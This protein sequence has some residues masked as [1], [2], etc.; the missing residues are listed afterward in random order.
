M[1][2]IMGIGTAY[3]MLANLVFI[4]SNYLLHVYLGRHL[5]PEG[6]GVFGI[7]M[8]IYLINRSFLNTGFPKSVSKAI[9]ESENQKNIIAKKAIKIEFLIAFIFSLLYIIFADKIALLLNDKGLSNY[10]VLLGIILV[11]LSIISLY[12]NGF[13]NGTRRFL[14]QAKVKIIYSVVRVLLAILLVALGLNVFGVLVGYLIAIIF[15]IFVAKSYFKINFSDKRKFNFKKILL[16]SLPVTIAALS[17]T[18]IKNVN[19]LF[20]KSLIG[21]NFSV[22]IYTAAVTLSNISYMVFVA[23]PSTLMPSISKAYSVPNIKLASKYVSKSL[24]YLFILLFPI[25]AM[26]SA[27]SSELLVL[28]YSKNFIE[29]GPLLSI[30]IIASTFLIISSTLNSVIT[31]SG[32]PKVEMFLGLMFI[33]VLSGLNFLLIP[34]KGLIGAALSLLITSFFSM[35]ISSLYVS[36]LL[37]KILDLMSFIKISISS[38]VIYCL[39]IN[40][41]INGPILIIYYLILGL[42]YF[43]ILLL[44]GEIKKEDIKIITNMLYQ[45]KN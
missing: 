11:P 44:I 35:A 32:K 8:S 34:W 23:V 3:L 5:G 29:G 12:L 7:I 39:A 1:K 26:I 18:L 20:I 10:I 36:Y 17:F 15:S 41:E 6:Y 38:L 24:R 2:K 40:L 14:E 43:L 28:F 42:I 25:T 9:A 21:D 27:T 30:L 22:G 13:F 37:R 33:F 16:F 45:I 19:I 31:G 4:L